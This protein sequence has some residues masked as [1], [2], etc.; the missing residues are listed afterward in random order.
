[1]RGFACES[2]RLHDGTK[3]GLHGRKGSPLPAIH[4]SQVRTKRGEDGP[5][6]HAGGFFAL[7][8]LLE[9]KNLI[10]LTGIDSDAGDHTTLEVPDHEF[11]RSEFPFGY[12]RILVG[13]S[14]LVWA[15]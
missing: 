8:F 9:I 3:S 1:M 5:P 7:L 11:F 12:R 10:L 4:R 14:D 2:G 15:S 13:R 6:V